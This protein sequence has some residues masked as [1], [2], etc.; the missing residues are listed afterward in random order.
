[1]ANE[2]QDRSDV[3]FA[4]A[5]ACIEVARNLMHNDHDGE[6]AENYLRAATVLMR[7][8]GETPTEAAAERQAA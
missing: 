8:Y 2:N 3:L 4:G 6:G 1:M 5:D 7:M